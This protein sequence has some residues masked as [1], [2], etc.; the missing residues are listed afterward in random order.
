MEM[1]AL[2]TIS[3]ATTQGIRNRPRTI[4]RARGDM[5]QG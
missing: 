5:T 4:S 3:P 1:T 2:A